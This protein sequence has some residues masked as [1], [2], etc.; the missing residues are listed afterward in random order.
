VNSIQNKKLDLTTI[1]NVVFFNHSSACISNFNDSSWA[2]KA[3]STIKSYGTLLLYLL[4]K[5]FAA[6][7]KVFCKIDPKQIECTTVPFGGFTQQKL[8][9][10]IH[11]LN[12]NSKQ[13]KK[14][15]SEIERLKPKATDIY[16]PDVLEK[17]N[18]K[19]DDMAKPIFKVIKEWAATGGEKELIL[20]GISNGG[21]ISRAIEAKLNKIRNNGKA[22]NITKFKFVSIVG[23]SRGSD[24]AALAHKLHLSWVMSK[25]I[26][27]EMPS[28]SIR[29]QQLDKDW[30]VESTSVKELSRQYFFI[31]SPHDWQ[32]NNYD[33]TLM[34]VNHPDSHSHYA[35]I[36][37]HGHNSIVNAVAKVVAEVAIS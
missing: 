16:I 19:L 31:A 23:A 25:N 11:G 6:F 26:A 22:E 21:R 18:A 4:D 5:L 2:Q 35:I 24:L 8:I 7:S 3:I 17:G 34:K 33:S 14:I 27:E 28:N 20:I 30:S 12:N 10:C 15:Q 37:G 9:I 32:V 29:N 36:P 1:Q 13:F